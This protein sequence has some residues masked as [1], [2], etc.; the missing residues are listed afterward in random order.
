MRHLGHRRLVRG[1]EEDG[2]R[3]PFASFFLGTTK[4]LSPVVGALST[5]LARKAVLGLL[6]PV[7]SAQNN[8]LNSTQGS[9]ELVRPVTGRGGGLNS[10]HLQTLSEKRRDRKE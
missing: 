8:Y 7:T 2:L 3:N 5:M 4:I 1:S 9:S 10:D 6:N